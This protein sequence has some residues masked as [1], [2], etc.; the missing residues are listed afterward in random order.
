MWLVPKH[1][2]LVDQS[3]ERIPA[4]QVIALRQAYEAIATER[5]ETIAIRLVQR[6]RTFERWIACDCAAE[7]LV[8]PLLAPAYLTT[9]E[10]YYLK[11]LTGP[12][13]LEH[14]PGCPFHRDRPEA[15][16]RS[17]ID[18]D[19]K[20][21]VQ[22]SGLFAVLPGLMDPHFAAGP[23]DDE[24]DRTAKVRASPRLARQLWRLLTLARRN[25]LP[26]I[27]TAPK[28]DLKLEFAALEHA[29]ERLE[30]APGIPLSEVLGL[31]PNALHSKA[32][33]ARLRSLSARWPMENQP[34][35]YLIVYAN[36]VAA[37]ALQFS[38]AE[39]IH[40]AGSLQSPTSGDPATRAPYLAIA[41]IAQHADAKG[42]AP[43]RCWAQPILSSSQFLP[44][45]S[46]FERQVIRTVNEA[47]WQLYRS[48]PQLA[49]TLTRPLFDIDTA[50]GPCMPDLLVDIYDRSNHRHHRI[51]IQAIDFD[52]PAYRAA[53]EISHNRMQCLGDILTITPDGLVQ[54]KA[55]R[56]M[57]PEELL[58]FIHSKP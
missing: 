12:D 43:V 15:S 11:R 8:R 27:G 29:A 58:R 18:P 49:I 7:G 34:Q 3:A 16:L 2:P 10:T 42:F 51:V 50:L 25:M 28:P 39:P 41:A 23:D 17:L 5:A 38:H 4:D 14:D 31:H 45:N 33:Y 37:R 44:V 57:L 46:D 35:A 47:R 20:P 6:A 55:E 22:P 36:G 32:I 48:H 53:R 19:P 52:V 9:T 26:A 40:I 56:N 54:A 1:R 13:R 21:L 24:T 30:V